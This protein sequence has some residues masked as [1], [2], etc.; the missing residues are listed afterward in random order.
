MAV[1]T[2]PTKTEEKPRARRRVKPPAVP[3]KVTLY[4]AL[5]DGNPNDPQTQREFI[6]NEV[7][8]LPNGE[9]IEE[10]IQR[11][12]GP[13]RYRVEYRDAGGKVS[14]VEI[15]RIAGLLAQ[16]PDVD[17]DE[18]IEGDGQIVLSVE[19]YN[20]LL[21]GG[22][23]AQRFANS[24]PPQSSLTE[25]VTALKQL[26]DLRGKGETKPKDSAAELIG[27]LKTL[28]EVRRMFA[29]KE[30]NPVRIERETELT[31][32]QALMKLIAEDPVALA[33]MRE[34]L[35]GGENEAVGWLQAAQTFAPVIERGLSV[36]TTIIAQRQAAP[37]MP[38]PM[39][40]NVPGMPPPTHT[41]PAMPPPAQHPIVSEP[42][43]MGADAQAYQRL[44][45]RLLAA[46]ETNT[47]VEPIANMLDGFCELF[48][49]HQKMIVDLLSNKAE[50]LL[51]FIGQNVPGAQVA[52]SAPHALEWT[53]KLMAAFF[54]NDDQQ[55]S[56]ES[57]KGGDQ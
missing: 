34:K 9:G 36:L 46:M 6:A 44:I 20:R 24:A 19:Q 51:Q 16:P 37:V 11:L 49:E 22:L 40:T 15:V 55:D 5:G 23:P 38:P 53:R 29:P 25:M 30:A 2:T 56:E 35:I 27:Q 39:P 28:D 14:N 17:D 13:S 26:D 43:P 4:R 52:A 21:T 54:S 8:P 3:V 41:A 45:G 1:K 18:V 47:P 42:P 48:P 32:E 57:N 7:W 10:W 31:T 33:M 12:G 50:D